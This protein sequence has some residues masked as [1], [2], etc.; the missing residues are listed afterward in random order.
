MA[1]DSREYAWKNIDIVML[2]RPVTGLRSIKY[3]SKTDKEPIY[4]RGSKPASIAYGNESFEGEIGLLQSELEALVVAAGKGK[5]VTKI[6]PF[7]ITVAYIP[8][9]GTTVITDIIKGVEIN[10]SEKSMKQG[11]KFMEVTIPFIALDI[12]Y[13]V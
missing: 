12:E 4:A 2:G 9:G 3:K 5:N 11:D 8:D 10:E 6:P 1:F 7:D 13:N